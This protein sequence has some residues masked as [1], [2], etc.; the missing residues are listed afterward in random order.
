MKVRLDRAETARPALPGAR[1]LSGSVSRTS[2]RADR[3]AH[4]HDDMSPEVNPYVR[5][6][7]GH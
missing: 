3:H 5:R 1:S 4:A 7:R 6:G 2:M